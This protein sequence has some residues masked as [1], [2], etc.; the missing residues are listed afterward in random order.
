MIK[1]DKAELIGYVGIALI[2]LNV[3]PAVVQAVRLGVSAPLSSI[4]LMLTGL[5]L[6]LYNSISTG[7]KLYTV[8]NL[9]GFI[10][11]LILLLAVI[12]K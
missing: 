4:I 6:C 1:F 7:N 12:L 2:Q 11:N 10:G 3:I 9:F 5:G 8:G